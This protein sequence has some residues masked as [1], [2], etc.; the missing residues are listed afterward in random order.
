MKPEKSKPIGIL[1]GN[2]FLLVI[3]IGTLLTLLAVLTGCPEAQQMMKPVVTEPEDTTPPVTVG[4][5][6]KPEETPTT[7]S[8]KPAEPTVP[9]DTTPPTVIEV[10]W[11][12]DWQ[13]IEPLTADS[14][15]HPG[16]TVYTVVVFSEPVVHTVAEDKTARPALSIVIDG[17]EEQYKMLP[18]GV[19]FKS[20]EAKPLR[21]GTDDYLCKYTIPA[22]AVGTLT[23]RVGGATADMAGNTVTEASEHVA[24]FVIPEPEPEPEPIVTNPI[25]PPPVV[26]EPFEQTP[27]QKAE[28]IVRRVIEFKSRDPAY[29]D[30]DLYLELIERESGLAYHAF[31]YDVLYQEIYLEERPEE[32]DKGWIWYDLVIEYRRLGFLYPDAD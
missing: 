9:A 28:A 20:G 30:Y 3:V 27:L 17:M 22:D 6:K 15:V 18:H 23:L 26:T 10:G 14:T 1:V 7:E 5:V 11:Y 2:F 16:D 32:K 12:R 29:R 25:T 31:I 4:E 8:E 19:G 21:G 13:M 24:P